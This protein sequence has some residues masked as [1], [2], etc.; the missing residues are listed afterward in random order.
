MG[1]D[2]CRQNYF[3]RDTNTI[4]QV[5]AKQKI[6]NLFFLDYLHSMQRNEEWLKQPERK[7]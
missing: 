1:S 3:Q 4:S 5:L 6:T 7:I 2:Y